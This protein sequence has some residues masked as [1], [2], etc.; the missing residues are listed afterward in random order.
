V[1]AL[2]LQLGQASQRYSV[3]GDLALEDFLKLLGHGWDAVGFTEATRFHGELH[4][5][6][7]GRNYWL[8]LPPEGD[9]A[10]AVHRDHQVLDHG[11]VHVNDASHRPLHSP[12]GV[13][14]LTFMPDSSSELVTFA[15]AHWLTERSDNGHQRL[16][17]T[18]AM[19]SVMREAG[20][21]SRLAFW[22]GDTNNPD[23]PS[24]TSDVDLALRRGELT[25][26]WDELGRYPDTHGSHTLDL[27]GSFDPDRR[28]SCT[29]ARVYARLHSDH[30]PLRVTYAVRPRTPR[31]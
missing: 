28:V 29:G 11:Y 3:P 9:T 5:A 12:R 15:E 22:A 1:S 8:F 25:S 14:V 16:A 18:Q 30:R 19:A 26:C 6:C 20:R 24:A 17:M 31:G 4:E 13:Q 21:G 23:R 7:R 10:I 2:Q 27:V